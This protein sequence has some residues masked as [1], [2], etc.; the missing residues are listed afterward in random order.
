M[1]APRRRLSSWLRRDKGRRKDEEAAK[2][3]M[4]RAHSLGAAGGAAV[5]GGGGHGGA[6]MRSYIGPHR[7][8]PAHPSLIFAHSAAD[9]QALEQRLSTGRGTREDRLVEL[10]SD[11]CLPVGLMAAALATQRLSPRL[12]RALILNHSTPMGV[13]VHLASDAPDDF[14]ANPSVRL[15]RAT[16]PHWLQSLPSRALCAIIKSDSC[17]PGLLERLSRER[18]MPMAARAAAASCS[19]LNL[20][21][22]GPCVA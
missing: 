9:R 18:S 10:L 12:R 2:I 1:T 4:S 20:G 15:Q 13:L 6:K 11:P 14:M 19:T 3:P 22:K 7:H 8:S 21:W 5:G 17:P 16:A